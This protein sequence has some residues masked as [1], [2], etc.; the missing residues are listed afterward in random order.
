MGKMGLSFLHFTCCESNEKV[1]DP[2]VKVVSWCLFVPVS[3][4]FQHIKDSYLISLL[5]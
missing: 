1:K 2:F 5:F 3:D 4:N